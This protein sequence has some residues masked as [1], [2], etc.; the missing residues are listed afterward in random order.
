MFAALTG[1]GLSAAAGLNAY[2]PFL[3]VALLSRFTEA[4]TLPGHFAWIESTW[5]ISVASVLLLVEV[6]FDKVPVV[7]HINDLISTVIR[8]ASG[9]LIFAASQAAD[10]F[11]AGT[12]FLAENPWAS[13]AGGVVVALTV[14]GGKAATRAV[15]NGASFGLG[16]PVMSTAEDG[17]SIGL[18]LL[19][20]FAPILV[21]VVL[22]LMVWVGF[23]IW[24]RGKT[25]R[26]RAEQEQMYAARR[27][28]HAQSGPYSG[29]PYSSP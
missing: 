4:I 25:K 22:I 16:A 14:H 27:Q 9:G 21:I 6:V 18:S 1:V 23:M 26:N 5:A 2:I 29:G 28:Q 10:D 17:T 3:V 24:S 13:A 12:P 15:V 20:I 19:A 8:P 11:E 7:D